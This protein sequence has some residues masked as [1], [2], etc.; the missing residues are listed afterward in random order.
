[1][2]RDYYE[3]LQL[4]PNAEAE[5]IQA[6]YRRL[7]LKYHPDVYKGADAE[8]RM[9]ELNEA[10]AVLSL[11]EKRVAYDRAR[12]S[13]SRSASTAASL[14]VHPAAIDLGEMEAGRAR[15][16][17]ARVSNTGGAVLNGFTVSH[18]PWVKVTPAEFKGNEL[19]LVVRAQPP[20]PG[21]FWYPEGIEVFSNGGRAAIGIRLNV[22]SPRADS[23]S[24]VIAYPRHLHPDQRPPAA[25]D[26]YFRIS[27]F[28]LFVLLS[29]AAGSSV[30]WYFINPWLVALPVFLGGGLTV[31]KLVGAGVLP[32]RMSPAV[33]GE[34]VQ[35]AKMLCGHCNA[36]LNLRSNKRCVRCGE[37]ICHIC[38]KCQCTVSRESPQGRTK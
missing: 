11:P 23:R 24:E 22:S 2:T 1:M 18:I 3:V 19:D 26:P 32:R 27:R 4:H 14:R 7:S 29:L 36:R 6:A 8:L 5:V 16:A 21:F 38:K 12:E 35:V 9:R 25:V 28:W 20:R 10:Y 30:V 37:F 17:V 31:W 33:R 13:V 34:Q 15:T